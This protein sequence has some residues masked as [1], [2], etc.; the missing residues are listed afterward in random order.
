MLFPK[1]TLSQILMLALLAAF[2]SVVLAAMQQGQA[3]AKG[4]ALAAGMAVGVGLFSAVAYW[5]CL[6]L[7]WIGFRRRQ[8]ATFGANRVGPG[9]GK[10]SQADSLRSQ[11]D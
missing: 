5:F 6:A 8:S 10:S 4:L 2:V 9:P 11:T 1:F 3:W 7:G